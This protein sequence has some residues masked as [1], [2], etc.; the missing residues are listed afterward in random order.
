VD[1][2]LLHTGDVLL[3]Q[4][5]KGLFVPRFCELASKILHI[6]QQFLLV[7]HRVVY[8][9]ALLRFGT[10]EQISCEARQAALSHNRILR[11]AGWSFRLDAPI[12]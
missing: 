4:L 12:D 8:H 10:M 6:F 7:N 9:R 3:N 2:S 1:A 11:D 5:P